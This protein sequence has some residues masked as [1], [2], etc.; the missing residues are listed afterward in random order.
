MP[1][2]HTVQQGEDLFTIAGK[3]GF[4]DASKIEQAN[5]SLDRKASIL[6]PGD[7]LTIPDVRPKPLSAQEKSKNKFLLTSPKRTIKFPLEDTEGKPLAGAK[8]T[9]VVGG[10]R[11]ISLDGTTDASGMVEAEL[12]WRETE[13]TLVLEHATIRLMLG[14]LNPV[15]GTDDGGRSGVAQRL[16]ILGFYPGP[17]DGSDPLLF[18][19]AVVSFQHDNGLPETGEADPATVK[20]LDD[21]VDG[22]G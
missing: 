12:P 20:K 8:Y 22:D 4:A 7:R 19:N 9:I 2:N 16:A 21:L 1:K 18:A 17:L 5:A 11:A 13:A 15:A 14:H 10:D 3:Y 6:H